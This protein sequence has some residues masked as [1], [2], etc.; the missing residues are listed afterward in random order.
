M[1]DR[2]NEWEKAAQED[3]MKAIACAL[4]RYQFDITGLIDAGNFMNELVHL[5]NGFTF[6]KKRMLEHGCGS[7]RMTQFISTFFDD[8]TCTDV[9]STM[10][11]KNICEDKK[12]ESK[13]DSIPLPDNSIDIIFSFTVLMHNRKKVVHDIF[14]E[15]FR[16]LAVG[17][18]VIFQLPIYK[19]GHEGDAFNSVSIWTIDEMIELA[20]NN[21]FKV[22]KLCPS[23]RKLEIKVAHTHFSYHIFQK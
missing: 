13:I 2:K 4:T 21:N 9:S 16:L 14:K 11:E 5:F 1:E 10:L 8:Y 15:F 6:Q 17:G 12:I 7:G 22:I 23:H 3:H 20:R 18:Y 19:M